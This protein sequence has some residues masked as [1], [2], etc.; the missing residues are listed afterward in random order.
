[1]CAEGDRCGITF[2]DF[3]SAQQPFA[4][5]S[6]IEVIFEIAEEPGGTLD[7][8]Q[9]FERNAGAVKLQRHLI[10]MMEVGGRKECR[11]LAWISMLAGTK[12]VFDGL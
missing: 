10:R 9:L 12:I 3:C 4:A 8:D 5:L 1:V 6:I 7:A 11:V 2:D